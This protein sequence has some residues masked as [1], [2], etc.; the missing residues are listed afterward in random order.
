[1][2]DIDSVQ[3]LVDTIKARHGYINLLVNNAGVAYNLL[4]KLPNPETGDIKAFQQVLLQ[5]GSRTEFA[6]TMEMNVSAQYYCT[7]LFLELLDAGNKRDNMHGVTSQII[8]VA[9]GGGFRQDDKIFSVSYTLSKGAAIH[10]GKLLAHFLKDWQIRSNV[11]A[12]GIFPSGALSSR[13]FGLLLDA[14]PS[15]GVAIETKQR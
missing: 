8:T 5:A 9:S 12:P 13:S 4:P 11:I 7:L 15:V 3:S 14:H 2:S 10:L 1:M 6:Y